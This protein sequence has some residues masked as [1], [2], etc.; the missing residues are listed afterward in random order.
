MFL[1]VDVVE[2]T[3]DLIPYR[4]VL[5]NVRNI[6]HIEAINSRHQ[7]MYAANRER[8][9]LEKEDNPSVQVSNVTELPSGGAMLLC[10]DGSGRSA[11]YYTVTTYSDVRTQVLRLNQQSAT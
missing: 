6:A 3:D 7:A 5:I 10:N 1:D 9:Q 11:V 2:F 4:N 8:A